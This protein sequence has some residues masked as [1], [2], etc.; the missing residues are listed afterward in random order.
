[1]TGVHEGA[2]KFDILSIS[3]GGCANVLPVVCGANVSPGRL[4]PCLEP[5]PSCLE[6]TSLKECPPC[7]MHIALLANCILE[8]SGILRL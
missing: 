1:M 6:G 4:K 5:L 2:V 3:V 7:N 8:H